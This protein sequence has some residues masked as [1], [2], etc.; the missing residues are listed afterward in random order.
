M[1]RITKKYIRGTSYP[2]Y[3]GNGIWSHNKN[4]I[5]KFVNPQSSEIDR[6]LKI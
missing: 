5:V 2:V 3:V 1:K 6:L 4:K